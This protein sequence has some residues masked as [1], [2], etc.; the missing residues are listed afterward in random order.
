M[1]LRASPEVE[2]HGIVC[3]G[4]VRIELD[5][6]SIVC[7]APVDDKPRNVE[8]TLELG[9]IRCKDRCRR[10]DSTGSQYFILSG[11]ICRVHFEVVQAGRIG[12]RRRCVERHLPD[13]RQDGR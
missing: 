10:V 11:C 2:G 13:S 6:D 4:E 5:S 12:E 9:D 7:G 3:A 1:A 8:R